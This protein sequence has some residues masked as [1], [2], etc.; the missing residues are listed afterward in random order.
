MHIHALILFTI[1]LWTSAMLHVRKHVLMTCLLEVVLPSS[2][3]FFLVQRSV[4]ASIF[5]TRTITV[6]THPAIKELTMCEL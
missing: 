6:H 1:Y 2:L 3:P 5:R 4:K